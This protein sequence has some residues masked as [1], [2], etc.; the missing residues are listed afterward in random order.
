MHEVS[1][2]DSVIELIEHAAVREGFQRVRRVRLEIG[3]LACVEV[4]ALEAAFTAASRGRCTEHARL[5][6]TPIAGEGECAACGIF[7][8][9]PSLYELCPQCGERPL[10][11]HRGTEMRVKDLDVE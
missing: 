4:E 11:V 7:A 5:E 9:M 1:L 10:Q 2:A 8:P 3:E 6:I